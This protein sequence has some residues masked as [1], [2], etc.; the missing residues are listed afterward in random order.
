[1]PIKAFVRTRSKAVA[2]FGLATCSDGHVGNRDS[3]WSGLGY[4][5]MC[6]SCAH[7]MNN[8]PAVCTIQDT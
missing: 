4:P 3:A 7:S 6:R 5:G 8:V 1:V 2:G